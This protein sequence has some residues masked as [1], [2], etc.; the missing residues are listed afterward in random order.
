M[1]SPVSLRTRSCTVL[2]FTLLLVLPQLFS[3]GAILSQTSPQQDSPTSQ[4]ESSGSDASNLPDWV[5]P[6]TRPAEPWPGRTYDLLHMRRLA[7]R[8]GLAEQRTALKLLGNQINADRVRASDVEVMSFLE[9]MVL[10]GIRTDRRNPGSPA[11]SSHARALLRAEAIQLLSTIGGPETEPVIVELLDREKDAF[12]LSYAVAA[13]RQIGKA[14]SPALETQL[15]AVAQRNNTIMRDEALT[16]ELIH[17][18]EQF[19][20]RYGH[21][22]EPAMFRE[23]LHMAQNATSFSVR[24]MAAEAIRTLR[25]IPE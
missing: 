2:S 14:P 4:A 24:Q 9:Q 23:I 21:G 13:A 12:V 10:T 1:N 6:H 8:G 3:P 17:T 19:Y 16:R 7:V 5:R 25:G 15:T 22:V 18:T 11:D 20:T